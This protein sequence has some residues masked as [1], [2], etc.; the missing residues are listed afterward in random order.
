[1]MSLGF[2]VSFGLL[3]LVFMRQFIWGGWLPFVILPFVNCAVAG[4]LYAA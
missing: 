1:M 2:C 4:A 3:G